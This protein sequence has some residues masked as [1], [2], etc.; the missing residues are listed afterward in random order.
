MEK[1]GANRT[2]EMKIVIPL[3]AENL[4]LTGFCYKNGPC[5]N[6]DITLR[7]PRNGCFRHRRP[8]APKT[9][10]CTHTRRVS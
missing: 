1:A 5:Q 8:I 2:K 6:T 3:T 4:P 7:A 10:A 9:P